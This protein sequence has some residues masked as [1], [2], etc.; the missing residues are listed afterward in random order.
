MGEK[1]TF[2]QIL[3]DQKGRKLIEQIEELL[4]EEEGELLRIRTAP[5][6]KLKVKFGYTYI[7]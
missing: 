2:T 3:E 1:M 7:V 4:Y 5:I 6:E